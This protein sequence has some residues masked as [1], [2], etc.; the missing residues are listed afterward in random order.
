MATRTSVH[1]FSISS[2]VRVM[3]MLCHSSGDS[4][5]LPNL[6]SRDWSQAGAA[7]QACLSQPVPAAPG[8]VGTG[9]PRE[10][11]GHPWWLWHLLPAAS[12]SRLPVGWAEVGRD[13][14]TQGGQ[15]GTLSSTPMGPSIHKTL[16][17]REPVEVP[18]R[19]GTMRKALHLG[20][21]I[22]QMPRP[23]IKRP[24]PPAG[25]NSPA[26]CLGGRSPECPECG[27]KRRASPN[28]TLPN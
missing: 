7:R 26:F 8:S 15:P 21:S 20:H 25:H 24:L 16:P 27:W 18:P 9:S 6:G 3:T 13:L 11:P 4:K 10:S 2:M 14:E 23:V 28:S 19:P 17:S 22:S 1:S 12:P 5:R